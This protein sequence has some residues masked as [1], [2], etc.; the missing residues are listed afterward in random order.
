MDYLRA[1]IGNT[2]NW[3]EVWSASLVATVYSPGVFTPMDGLI[4]PVTL[5]SPLI[6]VGCFCPPTVVKPT[7]SYAGTVQAVAPLN[8]FGGSPLSRSVFATY[9]G[10]INRSRMIPIP[11]IV[12]DYQVY[13]RPAKWIQEME[14]G[15]F[16]YTG[17][18]GDELI[19]ELQRIQLIETQ[20]NIALQDIQLTQ[21][22]IL[23][24]L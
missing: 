17:S 21:A 23:S 18:F 3:T 4:L 15:F 11:R 16:E 14:V 6:V 22:D 1:A 5:S 20:Q 24:R 12:S 9:S 13:F 10:L 7:W 2:A 19:T 8:L